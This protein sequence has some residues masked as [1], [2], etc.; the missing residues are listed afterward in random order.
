[1]NMKYFFAFAVV[2][3][4]FSSCETEVELNAP[5]KS[6]TVVYGLLDPVQDTQWIKIRTDNGCLSGCVG[7]GKINRCDFKTAQ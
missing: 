4:L 7:R 1:M 6:T 2:A 3:L 5:Y